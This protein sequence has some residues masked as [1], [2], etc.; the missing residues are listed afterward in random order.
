MSFVSV[1]INDHLTTDLVYR[2]I[3]GW[4]TLIK[5]QFKSFISTLYVYPYNI[6][7]TVKCHC[8]TFFYRFFTYCSS[9]LKYFFSYFISL[10]KGFLGYCNNIFK[11][12]LDYCYNLYRG[13]LNYYSVLFNNFVKLVKEFL[14]LISNSNKLTMQ[15]G[16][17]DFS[18][19]ID[20]ISKVNHYADREVPSSSNTGR[21]SNM[22]SS[23][24]SSSNNPNSLNAGVGNNTENSGGS[25]RK[26]RVSLP[27]FN[28]LWKDR[29]ILPP[30]SDAEYERIKSK[31]SDRGY[32]YKSEAEVV[33]NKERVNMY[34]DQS[35]NVEY[36]SSSY[37]NLAENV[38]TKCLGHCANQR[39]SLNGMKNVSL[40]D[41]QM[42][43]NSPEFRMLAKA[44]RLFGSRYDVANLNSDN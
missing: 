35:V 4:C 18:N 25:T 22:G 13:Y 23:S 2:L 20:D 29:L 21:S 11:G 10:S 9:L 44:I 36:D 14:Y 7:T 27:G 17:D 3:C 40:D 34:H 1:L 39:Q 16:P 8:Y 38:R 33:N 28:Q 26:E 12:Y 6:V 24:A 37:T 43:R 41:L 5:V 32:Y 31:V 15:S 42:D 30:I 19:R